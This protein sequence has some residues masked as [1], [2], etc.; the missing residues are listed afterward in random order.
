MAEENTVTETTVK[1][2]SGQVKV[3]LDEYNDLVRRA[4]EEKTIYRPNYTTIQKT[5][6]MAAN[7]RITRGAFTMTGGGLM[8][9]VG[10]VEFMA[11]RKA[12]KAL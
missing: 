5:P 9:V 7:D 1:K 10:L 6:E 2:S 4:N 12:L 8:F 11:G 3:D